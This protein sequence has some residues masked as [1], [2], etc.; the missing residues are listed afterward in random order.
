M[1]IGMIPLITLPVKNHPI[2]LL[3]GIPIEEA[4]A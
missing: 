2:Q 1:A 4:V 3:T